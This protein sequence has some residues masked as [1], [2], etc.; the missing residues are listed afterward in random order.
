M[1]ITSKF[2]KFESLLKRLSKRLY[3]RER[4]INNR[5]YK[6]LC[7]YL[8]N[9]LQKT[10]NCIDVG[11]NQGKILSQ[12]LKFAPNGTHFAIEP[13]P[14]FAKMIKAEYP[15]VKTYQVAA[16]D[17]DGESDF[18]HITNRPSYSGFKFR[19]DDLLRRNIENIKVR[20]VKLDTLI[21]QNIRIDFIKIDV[22]GAE[23]KVLNGA[24]SIIKKWHPTI[25]FEHIIYTSR[26]LYNIRAETIFELLTEDFDY[27]IF[28]M[29]G[30]VPLT[31][32]EFINFVESV[33][34][35]NFIA[36]PH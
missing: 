34:G 21:P 33:L 7:R 8:S 1:H 26:T 5:D 18:F 28:H 13:L 19:D 6:N 23:F 24:R 4:I 2:L 30:S 25:A 3:D 20:T 29:D 36:R 11:C 14:D 12:F 32:N 16:S 35:W 10:S 15:S 22:E 31:K 9:N 27:Y 17:T